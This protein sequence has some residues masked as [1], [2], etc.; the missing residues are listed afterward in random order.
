MKFRLKNNPG[1]RAIVPNIQMETQMNEPLSIKIFLT[2]G[3]ASGLR[4]ADISNWSGKAIACSRNE[5]DE[6]A[7]REEATRPGVYFLIGNNN[8]G[9][10]AIV[11]NILM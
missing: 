11:S 7:K 2:K 5:L 8:S 3:S 9:Q 4:T 1:Q 6:L 10:R